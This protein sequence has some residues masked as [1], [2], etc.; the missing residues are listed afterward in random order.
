M[1]SILT[2]HDEL[3]D[4]YQH[5]CLSVGLT[6]QHGQQDFDSFDSRF[7]DID[8]EF[9]ESKPMNSYNIKVADSWDDMMK[10]KKKGRKN[11]VTFDIESNSEHVLELSCHHNAEKRRSYYKPSVD[12]NPNKK[13][14]I[15]HISEHQVG[16]KQLIKVDKTLGIEELDAVKILCSLRS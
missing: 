9:N 5:H 7:L 2:I 6:T 3:F 15:T 14:C 12:C 11:K 16:N 13:T 10:K 4:I 8:I 1:S